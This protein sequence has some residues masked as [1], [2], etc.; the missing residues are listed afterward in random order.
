MKYRVVIE[1]DEDGIFVAESPTL[2]GCT[3]QGKSREKAVANIRDAI[4]G[5]VM[6]RRHCGF[7]KRSWKF[8]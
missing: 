3:S 6:S 2:P 4:S 5:Y 8:K 7:P 1:P